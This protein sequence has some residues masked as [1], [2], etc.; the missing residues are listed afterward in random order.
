MEDLDALVQGKIDA[1]TEFQ[2]SISTLTDE[3]KNQKISEK[4]SEITKV[5]WKE[6]TEKLTKQQEIA[7]NQRKR[8]EIAERNRK[9]GKS[10]DEPNDSPKESNLSTQELYALMNAKVHLDDVEWLAKQSKL[11]GKPIS[12]LLGNDE[13]QAVLKLRTEKRSTAN[14]TNTGKTRI[15]TTRPDGKTLLN[16][17]VKDGKVPAPGSQEAEDLFWARRGGKK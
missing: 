8:A 15:G 14:A 3:E 1:D 5:V 9:S 17:L 4:R 6:T 13:V 11:E 16:E 12:D 2:S 7:E 10:G